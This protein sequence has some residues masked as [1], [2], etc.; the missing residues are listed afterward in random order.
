[1]SFPLFL[2]M[3]FFH[4]RGCSIGIF[5]RRSMTIRALKLSCQFHRL[6]QSSS[7]QKETKESLQAHTGHTPVG[8][9][10]VLAYT[11]P[12]LSLHP[13]TSKPFPLS[14]SA[15]VVS[16]HIILGSPTSAHPASRYP[17]QFLFFIHCNLDSVFVVFPN[18]N[19]L[20][21]L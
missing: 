14:T 15:E 11:A 3:Y 10:Q 21:I 18:Y 12:L 5:T 8:S 17:L 4:S 19:Y 13:N 1:M 20:C 7:S 9:L 16:V 6:V 2:G